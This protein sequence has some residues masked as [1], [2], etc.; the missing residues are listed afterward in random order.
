MGLGALVHVASLVGVSGGLRDQNVPLG[1]H[2]F[3]TSGLE[4]RM[5]C[6]GYQTFFSA[7][8]DGINLKLSKVRF[9]DALTNCK[10]LSTIPGLQRWG[11]GRQDSGSLILRTHNDPTTA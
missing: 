1:L 10:A 8:N 9:L 11:E 2:G 7:I 6:E 3:G 5:I 4:I